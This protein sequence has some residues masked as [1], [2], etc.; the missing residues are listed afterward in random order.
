[1]NTEEQTDEEATELA[2]LF[3]GAQRNAVQAEILLA[4]AMSEALVFQQLDN[5]IAN[6]TQI[7]LRL[8]EV[9]MGKKNG[10]HTKKPIPAGT[11]IPKNNQGVKPS[12]PTGKTKGQ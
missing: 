4:A 11:E 2:W 3:A 10:N 8:N 1:M 9:I 12:K 6:L 5:A 7:K